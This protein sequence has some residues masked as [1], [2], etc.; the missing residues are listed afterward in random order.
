M[1]FNVYDSTLTAFVT[2]IVGL[3]RLQL[4][5][6]IDYNEE[7]QLSMKAVKAKLSFEERKE[8]LDKYHIKKSQAKH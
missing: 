3:S 1:G 2:G 8:N 4:L 7:Q 6:N 5:R